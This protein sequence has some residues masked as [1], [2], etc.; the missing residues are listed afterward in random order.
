[1]FRQLFVLI[2][3]KSPLAIWQIKRKENHRQLLQTVQMLS[4]HILGIRPAQFL[5]GFSRQTPSLSLTQ[6][7]TLYQFLGPY[8][9]ILPRHE[10]FQIGQFILILALKWCTSK[11]SCRG[12]TIT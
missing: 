6:N 11:L 12:K 9:I 4:N 10:S 3:T 8:N 7:V 1:M 2:V 5:G